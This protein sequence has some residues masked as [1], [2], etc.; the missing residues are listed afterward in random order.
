MQASDLLYAPEAKTIL[1]L[2]NG[3][4]AVRESCED[5]LIAATS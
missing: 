4:Q 3:V 1:H 2:N 5:V